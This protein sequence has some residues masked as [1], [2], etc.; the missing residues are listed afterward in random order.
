MTRGPA[1]TVP[2]E[3]EVFVAGTTRGVQLH[4][5]QQIGGRHLD[6]DRTGGGQGV[7]SRVTRE[8][9]ECG[10]RGTEPVRVP[11]AA[12]GHRSDN[13]ISHRGPR[14]A[15]NRN[16][17]VLR[18][19]PCGVHRQRNC[20]ATDNRYQQLV[21]FAEGQHPVRDLSPDGAHEPFRVRVRVRVRVRL[22]G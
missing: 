12:G 9:Q 8:W 17:D 3:P 18:R 16:I 19:D 6:L 22:S 1:A 14:P 20:G 21:P 13:G 2:S 15:G 11:A 5:K 4:R 7:P 10:Q